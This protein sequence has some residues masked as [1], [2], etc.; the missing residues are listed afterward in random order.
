MN[1][2]ALSGLR[3]QR[4][5]WAATYEAARATYRALQAADRDGTAGARPA[6]PAT[7]PG[8]GYIG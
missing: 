6:E 2:Q 8:P 3:R 5:R 4:E 1:F 7:V